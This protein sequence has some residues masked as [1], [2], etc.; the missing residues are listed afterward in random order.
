MSEVG[1]DALIIKARAVA[2]ELNELLEQLTEGG[3]GVSVVDPPNPAFIPT[4][5][6]VALNLRFPPERRFST[7][8]AQQAT[9][10]ASP[11]YRGG[12]D[13]LQKLVNR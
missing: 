8:A 2:R 3:V 1:I 11:S 13:A 12:I 4:H 10:K 9:T 5:D 6:R 7:G